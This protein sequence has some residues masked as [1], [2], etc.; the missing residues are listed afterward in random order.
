MRFEPTA[1]DISPPRTSATQ[2]L[3]LQGGVYTLTLTAESCARG[4]PLWFAFAYVSDAR[5][6]QM[7]AE[8]VS[9]WTDPV[10][11]RTVRRSVTLPTGRYLF[12]A[13][14]GRAHV[15]ASLSRTSSL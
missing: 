9:P 7:I 3:E 6:H 1:L 10:R 12:V 8:A 4:T 13:R 5:Q 15:H 14:S 11:K 2:V